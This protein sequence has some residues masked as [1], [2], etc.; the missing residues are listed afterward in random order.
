MKKT[1]TAFTLVELLVVI[2]IIA[3]LLAV[4]MP[5]LSKARELAKRTICATNLRQ[6]SIALSAYCS[7]NNDYF[8]YN[9]T[10][11]PYCPINTTVNADGT[12]KNGHD[13]KAAPD[14]AYGSTIVKKFW[15]KY[16]IKR[17]KNIISGEN[18]VLFCPTQKWHRSS[19]NPDDVLNNGLCGYYTLTS[20][21]SWDTGTLPAGWIFERNNWGGNS[22]VDKKKAGGKY[23]R[24]PIVMDIKQKF[25]NGT[26][27]WYHKEGIVLSSHARSKGIPD[28]GDFLYEDGHVKWFKNNEAGLSATV[29]G[30]WQ[31][32][33][34]IEKKWFPTDY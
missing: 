8:P 15:D 19:K 7:A 31:C 1:N 26:W 33:Y 16:I 2:S 18:N 23:S 20:K 14:L 25:L 11:C 17:E 5:A 28:G 22:W 32:Y 29:S 12:C 24:L 34:D 13:W 3:V 4:L 6:W 9:G 30:Q 27:S 21:A 10:S